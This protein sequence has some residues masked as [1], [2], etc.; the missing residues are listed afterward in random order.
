MRSS[1]QCAILTVT[2]TSIAVGG[3]AQPPT[4]DDAAV[5]VAFKAFAE[6]EATRLRPK[7][8]LWSTRS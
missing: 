4:Q 1:L 5:V 3:E 2:L 6:L 7:W 8:R